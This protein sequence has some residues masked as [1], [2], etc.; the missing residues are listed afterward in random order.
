LGRD[1]DHASF[2]FT[3]AQGGK[4]TVEL[5]GLA[6]RDLTKWAPAYGA[7]MLSDEQ[8]ELTVRSSAAFPQIDRPG[9]LVV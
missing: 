7:P 2:I 4:S 9:H 6:T 1:P 8:A 3:G 5:V